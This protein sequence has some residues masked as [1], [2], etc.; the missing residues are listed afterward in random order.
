MKYYAFIDNK[1]EG[2]FDLHQLVD[3]GVRPSTYIWCKGMDDWQR[4]D[5]V[6]EVCELFRNHVNTSYSA[7]S[8][9]E[10]PHPFSSDENQPRPEDLPDLSDVPQS[11][12]YFV[13][14]SGT[15][16]GPSHSLDPDIERAPQISMALAILSLVMCFVPTGIAAVVFTYKS[17]KTWDK[18]MAARK[19]GADSKDLQTQAHE[20]AR[21]AK[22]WLGITVALG[23]IFWTLIFSVTRQ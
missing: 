16:P 13:R 12:R 14:K 5:Q 1:Q 9:P 4:A 17:Q 3:V 6:D 20:Y 15:V 22:M 7:K 18:A 21:Q 8:E 19:E 10:S 23:F 11:Y 2:P